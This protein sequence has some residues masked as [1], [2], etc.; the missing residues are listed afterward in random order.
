M[1][2]SFDEIDEL[3]L[4]LEAEAGGDAIDRS[5]GRALAMQL[6]ELYPVIGASMTRI[7]RR[8]ASDNPVASV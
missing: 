7:A 4:I 6:A 5:K 1:H 3:G 8:M 2:H